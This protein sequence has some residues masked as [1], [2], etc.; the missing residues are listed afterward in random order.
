MW[1]VWLSCR[2]TDDVTPPEWTRLS[3]A[4]EAIVRIMPRKKAAGGDID[5]RHIVV[6]RKTV[7]AQPIAQIRSS[8]CSPFPRRLARR[9]LQ[10][11]KGVAAV[12][13]QCVE[14]IYN[15]FSATTVIASP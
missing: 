15:A 1:L 10:P 7:Y 3:L 11:F 12:M 6:G 13:V 14:H 4:E 9:R 2:Q 5:N 8:S